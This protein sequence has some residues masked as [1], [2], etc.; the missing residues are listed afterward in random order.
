MTVQ[1]IYELTNNIAVAAN[2]VNNSL[3]AKDRLKLNNSNIDYSK[4]TIAE[5]KAF[6]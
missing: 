6:A 5:Q 3:T 4:S 2:N 1:Q